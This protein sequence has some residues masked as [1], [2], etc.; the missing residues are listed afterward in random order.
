LGR[1]FDVNI[2]RAAFEACIATWN[3]GINSA[4]SLGPKKITE[5]LDR[6]GKI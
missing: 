6:V 5:K 1:H 3:F 4:F 2:R